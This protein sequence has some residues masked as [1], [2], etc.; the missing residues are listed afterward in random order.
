MTWRGTCGSSSAPPLLLLGRKGTIRVRTVG[1]MHPSMHTRI[2]A[3]RVHAFLRMLNM[4]ALCL[5]LSQHT[6]THTRART[7]TQ[8]PASRIHPSPATRA[9]G[10]FVISVYITAWRLGPRRDIAKLALAAAAR[11][12]RMRPVPAAGAPAPAPAA[13]EGPAWLP[14]VASAASCEASAAAAW[15]CSGAII[16]AQRVCEWLSC[17]GGR[18]HPPAQCVFVTCCQGLHT[19]RAELCAAVCAACLH[20]CLLLHKL[21]LADKPMRCFGGV[22]VLLASSSHESTH[23]RHIAPLACLAGEDLV[24]R[25]LPSSCCIALSVCCHRLLDAARGFRLELS[26]DVN[27]Y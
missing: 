27:W 22:H 26:Q 13:P 14:C 10:E 18:G 8:I 20:N 5:P 3:Q 9:F 12:G 6:H 24:V 1:A 21:L 19:A 2:T 25:A 7:A 15:R 23:N 4:L 17:S 11:C 16:R